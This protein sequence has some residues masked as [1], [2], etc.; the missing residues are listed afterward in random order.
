ML[1]KKPAQATIEFAHLWRV[2][3]Y[4]G[5]VLYIEQSIDLY[6]VHGILHSMG[7]WLNNGAGED[8]DVLVLR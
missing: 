3:L 5:T 8:S 4:I 2:D 7:E 1:R 6:D